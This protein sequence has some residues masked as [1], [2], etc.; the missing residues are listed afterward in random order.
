MSLY[1][2]A[3][4]IA[5]LARVLSVFHTTVPPTPATPSQVHGPNSISEP[6]AGAKTLPDW[7]K[8]RLR[9]P[10]ANRR[11]RCFTHAAP[12]DGRALSRSVRASLILVAFLL[13]R[14]GQYRLSN[15]QGSLLSSAIGT[16]R[17]GTPRFDVPALDSVLPALQLLVAGCILSVK[18][19]PRARLAQGEARNCGPQSGASLFSLN[20]VRARRA[21]NFPRVCQRGSA[22]GSSACSTA[23]S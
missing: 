4:P 21:H 6:N 14:I 20:V 23:T 1:Q 3:W 12:E 15:P 7:P 13:I 10:F 16:W 8:T 19:P 5:T 17:N 2:S 9:R 22:A 11:D 18:M